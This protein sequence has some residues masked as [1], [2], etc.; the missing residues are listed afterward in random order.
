MTSMNAEHQAREIVRIAAAIDASPAGAGEL[1]ITE[2]C[3]KF[4]VTARALR[5]YECKSLLKPIRLGRARRYRPQD[6]E[7]LALILKAKTLGFSLHEI[8]RMFGTGDSEG[9]PHAIELTPQQCSEQ[10]RWLQ[11]ERAR[12]DA[13]ISELQALLQK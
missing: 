1:T 12:I 10:I 8:A 9:A 4:S 11:G 13:A 7:R 2:V 5:F 3:E 6:C